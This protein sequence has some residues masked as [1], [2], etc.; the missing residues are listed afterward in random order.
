MPPGIA[1]NRALIRLTSVDD[2]ADNGL[3]VADGTAPQQK[4]VVVETN[5]DLTGVLP[6]HGGGGSG[7]E[8][9]YITQ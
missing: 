5:A 9:M 4:V 8:K 2:E 3:C 7:Q 6:A 1:L